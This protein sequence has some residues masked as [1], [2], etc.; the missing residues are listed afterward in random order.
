MNSLNPI[1]QSIN[2]ITSL[3]ISELVKSRHDS[4]KRTIE[5]LAK[6]RVIVQ[7][8]LVDEQSADAIGRTRTTQVYIFSGEQG[9]L[10]S[11]TVVAQ[12]CPEFTAAIV[13]RWY[14][15]EQQNNKPTLDLNDPASLRQA[16]LGYTEKVLELEHKVEVLEPKAVA[17]DL[18][19][20]S[21][22]LYGIREAAKALKISERNFVN[23]LLDKKWMFRDGDR[24]LQG[25]ANR[26]AQGYIKHYASS[27]IRQGDGSERVFMRAMI[28]AKGLARLGEIIGNGGAV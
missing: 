9:K 26:I 23:F 4:V 10:D 5:R 11:I 15:L 27:P 2:K 1:N 8:P 21:S 17:L 13:K 20:D 22:G 18:I 3:E 7:P 24:K 16:L 19:A 14:E 25:Y 28:T 6:D 12:L